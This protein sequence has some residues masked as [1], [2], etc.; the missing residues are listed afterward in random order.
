MG[1]ADEVLAVSS[2]ERALNGEASLADVGALAWTTLRTVARPA[3]MAI[4]VNE[5]AADAV[6]VRFAAGAHVAALR[7]VR[8]TRGTGVAGW[9]AT[10]QR[11]VLNADPR[12]DLGS[13][14]SAL[15]PA[16][17][18]SLVVPLAHEGRVVAVMALYA[19]TVNA[20]TEDHQRLLELLSPSLAASVAAVVE[21]KP[22]HVPLPAAARAAGSHLRLVQR[23]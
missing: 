1:A 4:F 19:S 22:G 2:L 7:Q 11:S 3:A 20:F 17:V 10:N 5:E 14:A 18:S 13:T 9:T 21:S 16:L 15:E 23:H 12:L 8:V 6:I